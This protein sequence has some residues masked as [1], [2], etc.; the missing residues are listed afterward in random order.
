[1]FFFFPAGKHRRLSK[2]TNKLKGDQPTTR[3]SPKITKNNPS[4]Y[5]GR[6]TRTLTN[7]TVAKENGR[8]RDTQGEK[9]RKNA[10]QFRQQHCLYLFLVVFSKCIASCA[11]ALI[12][13]VV[14]VVICLLFVRVRGKLVGRI[15]LCKRYSLAACAGNGGG[16]R[17]RID[18][19]TATKSTDCGRTGRV[20]GRRHRRLEV[21]GNDLV[22]AFLEVDRIT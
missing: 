22:L 9:K 11:T 17:A 18:V 10:T 14:V 6:C 1:M 20:T 16:W 5:D 2:K 19:D 12:T 4:D 8:M 13:L 15:R 7:G 21:D 3:S